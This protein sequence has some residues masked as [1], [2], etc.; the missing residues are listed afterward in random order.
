MT[1]PI[2]CRC[3]RWLEHENPGHEGD[4]GDNNAP[5]GNLILRIHVKEHQYFKRRESDVILD[6]PINVAQAALGDKVMVSRRS[7]V[8]SK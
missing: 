4:V 2:L 6:M 7:T 1:V 8:M 3:Q 5:K